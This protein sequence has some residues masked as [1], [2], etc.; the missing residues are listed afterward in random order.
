MVPILVSLWIMGKKKDKRKTDIRT[1]IRIVR[2]NVL[3][4]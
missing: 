2:K 4:V 3:T 1:D